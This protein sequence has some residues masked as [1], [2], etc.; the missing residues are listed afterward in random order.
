MSNLTPS[1]NQVEPSNIFHLLPDHQPLTEA[2]IN[3]DMQR[4]I[5]AYGYRK[6]APQTWHVMDWNSVTKHCFYGTSFKERDPE[7]GKEV[8][9]VGGAMRFFFSVFGEMIFSTFNAAPIHI[10]LAKDGG[11]Q[12]RQDVFPD[13][14][15]KREAAKKEL[16]KDLEFNNL[17]EFKEKLERILVYAGALAI[18]VPGVE[19]DDI[20]GWVCQNLEGC[21]WVYT[22]DHDLLALNSIPGVNTVM[23]G[24]IYEESTYICKGLDRPFDL[25]YMTLFKSLIGDTSDE[26]GGVPQFG[27]AKWNDI[28]NVAGNAGLDELQK[29]ITTRNYT[30][31][32]QVVESPAVPKAL[33]KAIGI[34]LNHT[35][36]WEV[37]YAIASIRP[38]LCWKPY[39]GKM[40]KAE[41]RKRVPNRNEVLSTMASVGCDDVYDQYMKDFMPTENLIDATRWRDDMPERMRAVVEGSPLTAYDYE[42]YDTLQHQDFQEAVSRGNY[43]DTLSMDVTGGSACFGNNLQ[44]SVYFTVNHDGSNNLTKQNLADVMEALR[45]G[46]TV[47][48]AH[49]ATFEMAVSVNSLGIQM[50]DSHDTLIMS[51]EVD[52]NEMS[53]LKHLSSLWLRYKQVEYRDVVPEG[54]TMKDVTAESVLHYGADDS[55]VTAHLYWLEMIRCMLEKTYDFYCEH[56]VAPLNILAAESLKGVKISWDTLDN[57]ARSDAETHRVK[58]NELQQLLETNLDKNDDGK[59]IAQIKNAEA[60]YHQEEAYYRAKAEA[61]GGKA[62]DKLTGDTEKMAKLRK[63]AEDKPEKIVDLD[64]YAM[65]G[66]FRKYLD[67]YVEQRIDKVKGDLLADSIYEP[68]CVEEVDAKWLPT[69]KGLGELAAK[70]E[71]PELKKAGKGYLQDWLD[72]NWQVFETD[73]QKEFARLL[74]AV[75]PV[76]TS[77]TRDEQEFADLYKFAVKTLELESK[78]VEKGTDLDLN[79]PTKSK[80]LLYLLLGSPVWIRGKRSP[81]SLRDQLR[82]PGSPAANALALK[83]FQAHEEEE[84]KRSAVDCMVAMKTALTRQGLYHSKYPLWRHPKTDNIHPGFRWAATATGRPTGNNPNFLQIS[85]TMR[86]IVVP[87]REDHVLVGIDWAGLELRLTAGQCGDE[88]MVS[89]YVGAEMVE[90]YRNLFGDEVADRIAHLIRNAGGLVDLHSLTGAGMVGLAYEEFLEVY[91]DPEHPQFKRIE[92]ARKGAKVINFGLIYGMS[93]MS[94]AEKLIIAKELGDEYVEAYFRTYPGMVQWQ[95]DTEAEAKRMGFTRTAYGSVRHATDDLFSNDRGKSSRMARQLGN[96]TIQ[97]TAADMLKRVLSGLWKSGLYRQTEASYVLPIYDEVMSSVSNKTLELYVNGMRYLMEGMVPT[98]VP[99][100]METDVAI[101]YDWGNAHEFGKERD[102]DVIR[103]KLAELTASRLEDSI[104]ISYDEDVEGLDGAADEFEG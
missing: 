18:K 90:H 89:A 57:I 103:E 76:I 8:P 49:N 42:A 71:L 74:E 32:Q 101:G 30:A 95:K 45:D 72:E 83:W 79:S 27:P 80:N 6:V 82:L 53:G 26:Y 78:K 59:F 85:P 65:D 19:A 96:A 4:N 38:E 7:T 22:N 14:K 68:F 33:S 15:A 51:Q 47:F 43:V 104:S 46:S 67:T 12:Y 20:V 31:L 44:H 63:L 28:V 84:W 23:K 50:W 24:K 81:G 62:W 55:L 13:Y 10:I 73:G 70:L 40:T 94:L 69:A 86:Q 17:V 98:R 60:F 56:N 58:R 97:G 41:F 91:Q 34:I 92:K 87:Y 25:K 48:A 16:V 37:M 61:D 102:F 1:A 100:P 54:K 21:K 77:K 2:N 66:N 93:S 9:T 29:A 11:I 39:K 75:T 36:T 35:V 5:D 99:M 88:A 3:A 64:Q 52:E